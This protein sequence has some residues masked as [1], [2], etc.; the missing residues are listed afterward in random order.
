[1]TYIFLPYAEIRK[2][3]AASLLKIQVPYS[4]AI[5]II[6]EGIDRRFITLQKF[7]DRHTTE[8]SHDRIHLVMRTPTKST[9]F[10]P[11]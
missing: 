2:T 10:R 4:F 7:D 3:C 6:S 5:R 11:P 1:M 8:W 9:P